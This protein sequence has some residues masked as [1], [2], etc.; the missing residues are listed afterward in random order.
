M[1]GAD[2]ILIIGGGPVGLYGAYLAGLHRLRVRIVERLER[3]GGQA[4]YLFPDKPVYDVGGIPAITGRGLVEQLKQQAFQYPLKLALGETA[5]RL[6]RGTD[7]WV[8]ETDRR[9]Y[10]ARCVIIT[11]GIGEFTPRRLDNPAVDRW[12]GRGVHYVVDRLAAFDDRRVLVVGGGNSAA[13]WA[14]ALIPRARSVTMIHRRN[15]FQCHA[16]SLAKLRA[17]P[18]VTMIP[19]A[20]LDACLGEDRVTAAQIRRLDR[21]AV[22][23][24][25]VDEVI[26]AIGL[27]PQPGPLAEWGL[28]MVGAEIQ[29]DARMATNLPMV[30]AA[31]D[32]VHYPG[33]VK[34]IA[35]GFGEVATAVESA[36]QALKAMGITRE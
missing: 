8:V 12:E 15:E 23:T 11:A 7:L 24:V 17:A 22:E 36:R 19:N 29:V 21:D 33:K 34:L 14:M 10:P 26:V 20:A 9:R 18:N 13:D 6:E 30:Y 2:D 4:E 32:I 28:V 16:D 31:G 5:W 35:T 3:L 25:P 27:I 1:D